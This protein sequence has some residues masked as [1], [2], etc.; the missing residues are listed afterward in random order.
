MRRFIY[1]AEN[2]FT[3]RPFDVNYSVPAADNYNDHYCNLQYC[4]ELERTLPNVYCKRK[5]REHSCCQSFLIHVKYVINITMSA[6]ASRITS[7][8][9]VCSNIYSGADQRKNQSSASL[10][11]VRGIHR[12]PVNSTHEGPATWKMFPF[13]D[14][15]LIC[16]CSKCVSLYLKF[17]EKLE[18]FFIVPR[19]S[20]LHL[21][22]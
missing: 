15:M 16:T 8:T 19:K 17:L 13:D 1:L 9:L 4:A 10:A 3:K 20:I 11:F 7:L 18:K 2:L 6:M 5:L 14:V 22:V 12:W 21:K